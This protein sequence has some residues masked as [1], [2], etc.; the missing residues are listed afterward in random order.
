MTK[1]GS[2]CRRVYR[3]LSH[4]YYHHRHIFDDFEVVIVGLD[5]APSLDYRI[6]NLLFESF[7]AR[8]ESL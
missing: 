4:A 8:D 7:A 2:V 6:H 5:K 1:L 3:I